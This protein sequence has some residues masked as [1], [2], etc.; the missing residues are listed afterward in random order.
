MRNSRWPSALAVL[1]GCGALGL[2]VWVGRN[3][4]RVPAFL[5]VPLASWLL[6]AAGAGSAAWAAR[7]R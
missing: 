2:T 5:M 4:P 7:K 3:T 6:I 1:G